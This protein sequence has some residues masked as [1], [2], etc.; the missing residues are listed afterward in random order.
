MLFPV[1]SLEYTPSVWVPSLP[2]DLTK[3]LPKVP[4]QNLNK[5]PSS[6]I[7]SHLPTVRWI[8]VD[9]GVNTGGAWYGLNQLMVVF[10]RSVGKEEKKGDHLQPL[11]CRR[12]VG[13]KLFRLFISLYTELKTICDWKHSIYTYIYV[14]VY[15]YIYIYICIYIYTHTHTH[16]HTHTYIYIYK[17][18]Y[19]YIYTHIYICTY[20]YTY[21]FM[22]V[23]I[24]T[25]GV[26]PVSHIGLWCGYT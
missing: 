13:V 1:L 19:T 16:T 7:L 12:W 5:R 20:I 14:Y 6:R 21:I 18:I 4:P 23:T 15:I 17:Y 22:Y 26:N 3:D 2:K 24:L 8:P 11:E 25:K 9:P 10:E